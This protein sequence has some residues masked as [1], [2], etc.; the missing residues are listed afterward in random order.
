M[1]SSGNGWRRFVF[2][3]QAR[4]L[5]KQKTEHPRLRERTMRSSE[6]K[7]GGNMTVFLKK[8]KPNLDFLQSAEQN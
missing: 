7:K 4:R 3:G 5:W 2:S 8:I 6:M 1:I